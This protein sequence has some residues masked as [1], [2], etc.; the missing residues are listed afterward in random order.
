MTSHLYQFKTKQIPF[1]SF[2]AT[3]CPDLIP[4]LWN[5]FSKLTVVHR[6]HW[7]QQLKTDLNH[8]MSKLHC[9]V[10]QKPLFPDTLDISAS[11]C[12]KAG[13]VCWKIKL[14]SFRKTKPILFQ[15]FWGFLS[16][17]S[18]PPNNLVFFLCLCLLVLK[19]WKIKMYVNIYVGAVCCL[20]SRH[21]WAVLVQ[22]MIVLK[23]PNKSP[24]LFVK[25]KKFPLRM[26]HDIIHL[27]SLSRSFLTVKDILINLKI[28]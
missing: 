2:S 26:A 13:N 20:G 11:Y 22:D 4:K 27:Y 24:F 5:A 25:S 3:A 9:S 28:I 6:T 16:H 17:S 15:Q 19:T 12:Q 10:G 14:W 1:C 8:D 23:R 18:F 21:D 7:S